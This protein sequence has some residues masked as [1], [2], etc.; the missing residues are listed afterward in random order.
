MTLLDLCRLIGRYWK[1]VV[2]LPVLAVV[3]CAVVLFMPSGEPAGSTATSRIV[4][5][6]QVAITYGHA[7]SLARQLSEGD[8]DYKVS[9]KVETASMTVTITASGRDGNECVQLADAIAADA[10][11]AT[12]ADFAQNEGSDYKTA[13]RAQI[14]PAQLDEATSSRGGKLKYLAVA[15]LGGLFV[16]V[17]MVVVIDLKR[18]HVKSAEGVQEAVELPV[19]EVLPVADGGERLLAN[20]RFA[21]GKDDLSSVLVVPAGDMSVAEEGANLL[22]LAASA[23]G[24][25]GFGASSCPPLAQGMAGAYE[26]R[27]ADAVVVATRQWTD[28][29]K[30]LEPTIA[31]LKLAGAKLA[32][33]VFA[34]EVK[35]TR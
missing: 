6:S 28:S 21:A 19:L 4:V 8:T 1:L 35:E 32:G 24:A 17:C 11:S 2:A 34:K 16:A 27:D 20:V 13:Y 30:Q 7:A 31:E 23:E 9:A 14:E 26:A 22:K 33:I 5:N 10:V 3:V 29:M 15:L 18:R 12:E 25:S